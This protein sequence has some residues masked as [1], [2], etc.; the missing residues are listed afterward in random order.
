[1]AKRLFKVKDLLKRLENA[2]PEA[3]VEYLMHEVVYPVSDIEIYD[4]D[5]FL[6]R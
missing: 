5:V 4:N 2:N 1:M 6:K 3:R